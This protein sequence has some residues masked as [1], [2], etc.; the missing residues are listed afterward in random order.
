MHY[1]VS[2]TK[3]GSLGKV[4]KINEKEK[5]PRRVAFGTTLHPA[6]FSERSQTI[7]PSSF[8]EKSRLQEKTAMG[9]DIPYAFLKK[10]R[11]RNVVVREFLAEF[12]GTFILIVLGECLNQVRST[13]TR[14]I[15]FPVFERCVLQ[16]FPAVSWRVLGILFG[17]FFVRFRMHGNKIPDSTYFVLQVRT[18][19]L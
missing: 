2:I 10:L 19:N 15:G 18:R 3:S 8:P 11:V 14:G 13:R 17:D 4:S 1:N 5:K 16:C 9:D 12:L 6:S 7:V